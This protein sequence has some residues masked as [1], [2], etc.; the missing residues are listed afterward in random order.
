MVVTLEAGRCSPVNVAESVRQQVGFEVILL[1]SKCFPVLE[2]ETATGIDFWKSN[3]K[4]LA[5]SQSL[6]KRLTGSSTSLKRANDEADPSLCD[7]DVGP[8]KSKC[9]CLSSD[10]IEKILCIVK[11]IQE[12]NDLVEKI[13][14]FLNVLYAG[15]L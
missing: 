11:H 13:S 10:K 8:P 14:A 3:R 5:A 6:Y 9:C 12:K 4:I 1:D 15:M 2:S 7:E